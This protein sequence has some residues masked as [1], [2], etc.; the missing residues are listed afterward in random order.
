MY[1]SL[2]SFGVLLTLGSHWQHQRLLRAVQQ[3]AVTS[4][5]VSRNRFLYH[6]LLYVGLSYVVVGLWQPAWLNA[7][8]V[9][10][11]LLV[12]LIA[13]VMDGVERRQRQYPSAVR[14]LGR[15]Q[16]WYFTSSQLLLAAVL[17]GTLLGSP[18]R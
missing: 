12:D 11:L 2:L 18:Y 3:Q 15:R 1:T 7:R 9:G 16:A 6:G 8:V 13:V 4:E 5:R 17:L 10:L 14:A